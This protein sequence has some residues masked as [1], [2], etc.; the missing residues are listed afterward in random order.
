M[1]AFLEGGE[2][3]DKVPSPQKGTGPGYMEGPSFVLFFK[4][5]NLSILL[6]LL[7]HSFILGSGSCSLLSQLSP[8]VDFSIPV[9]F[10]V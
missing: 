9:E 3:W 4:M 6:I 7:I 10:W 8:L 5:D 1:D 2:P